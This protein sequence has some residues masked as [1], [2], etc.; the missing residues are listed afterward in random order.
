MNQPVVGSGPDQLGILVRWGY[1][2]YHA[3]PRH[4]HQIRRP[5]DADALG[6]IGCLAREVRAYDLPGIPAVRCLKERVSGEVQCVR[7]DRREDHRSSSQES[8][9]AA[10]AGFG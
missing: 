3:S 8:I 7:V 9:L 6:N 5:V 1:G 2:I 4:P 10:P